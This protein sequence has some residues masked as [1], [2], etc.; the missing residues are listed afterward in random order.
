MVPAA[1]FHT[2]PPCRIVDTRD[3]PGA[4]GG[5]AL[6]GSGLRTFTLTG[7]P[8]GVPSTE[9]SVAANLTVTQPAAAGHL[10]VFPAGSSAPL[11]SVINF[12]AGQTRANNAV[13]ELGTGGAV[14][15]QSGSPGTVHFILDVTGYFE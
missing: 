6:P 12:S 4:N 5:P 13:L 14:S 2:L 8:C 10:V 1:S 3:A 15:V 9:K 11:A 7:G